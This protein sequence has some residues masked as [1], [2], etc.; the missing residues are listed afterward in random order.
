M[1]FIRKKNFQEGEELLYAPKLHWMF[2]VRHMVLS[3][4]F[5][6][7]LLILWSVAGRY[8]ASG[9]YGI[10]NVL[11]LVVVKNVFLAALLI[12]LLVFVW[13]I[14]VYLNTEYGVTNRRLII[15]KGILRLV[16][17]EIPTDRIESIY[18]YQGLM[19]RIFNYGTVFISGIGGRMPIFHMVWRPY[20]LRRKI[21]EIIDK[22]KTITVVHGDLP[23]A[24]PAVKPQ[25]AP[26]EEPINRYGTFVRVIPE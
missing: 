26:D 10:E 19:G 23:K 13:R 16:I 11:L 9:W 1:K 21:F 22:N 20:T 7:V 3:L 25:P 6:L 12:V 14:F 15:K 8:A 5:F 18:C 4:P 17:A 24:K 2:T